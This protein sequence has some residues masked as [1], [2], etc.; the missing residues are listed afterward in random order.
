MGIWDT[1]SGDVCRPVGRARLSSRRGFSKH[2]SSF[3][4]HAPRDS[5]DAGASSTDDAVE[6]LRQG[7]RAKSQNG[8]R[9]VGRLDLQRDIRPVLPALDIHARCGTNRMGNVFGSR[10]GG[11]NRDRLIVIDPVHGYTEERQIVDFQLCADRGVQHVERDQ[12]P[13]V[14]CGELVERLCPRLMWDFNG[15]HGSFLFRAFQLV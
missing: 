7:S 15:L 6:G 9:S 4:C 10:A 12:P 11:R 3:C 13:L 5:G 2:G 14:D 8:L 1:K